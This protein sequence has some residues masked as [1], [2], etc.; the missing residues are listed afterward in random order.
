MSRP[1]AH[2]LGTRHFQAIRFLAAP[3]HQFRTWLEGILGGLSVSQGLPLQPQAHLS[4]VGSFLSIASGDSPGQWSGALGTCKVCSASCSPSS[5][6]LVRGLLATAYVGCQQM[7]LS[8]APA[9][10]S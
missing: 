9:R 5:G 4:T 1:E 2:G 10:S 3:A 6:L 8:P 7:H